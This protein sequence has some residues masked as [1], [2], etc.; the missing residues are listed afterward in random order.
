MGTTSQLISGIHHMLMMVGDASDMLTSL[1]KIETPTTSVVDKNWETAL[2]VDSLYIMVVQT[3]ELLAKSAGALNDTLYKIKAADF[4]FRCLDLPLS[5]CFAFRSPAPLLTKVDRGL[6]R[7]V[8]SLVRA[9]QE[10]NVY[11]AK[12]FRDLPAD[13]QHTYRED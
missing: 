3:T 11:E 6:I 4:F 10:T 7:P 13:E 5:C 9:K 2:I 8:A 1:E 12:T